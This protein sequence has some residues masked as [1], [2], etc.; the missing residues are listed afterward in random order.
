[1]FGMLKNRSQKSRDRFEFKF[2]EFQAFQVP[3]GWDKIFVS[4]IPMEIGK[5]I[6]KSGKAYVLDGSC[7]WEETILESTWVSQDEAS[8]DV[9]EYLLKFVVAMGS[10]R[11]GTLWEATVNLA[12]DTS[13]SASIAVSL[14]LKK[15][16][17]GTF[18]QVKIKCL[19]SRMTPRDKQ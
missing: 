7:H 5:F 8:T 10:V 1:M 4:I 17:H 6:A 9:D 3:K 19:T 15:C 14:Q 18:L 16:D 11:F 12:G 13:S 2:S